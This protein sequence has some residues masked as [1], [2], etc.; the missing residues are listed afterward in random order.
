MCIR[1]RVYARE[2]GPDKM[3]IIAKEREQDAS[4]VIIDDN[5]STVV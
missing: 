3:K 1:D 2:E 4:I 5:L